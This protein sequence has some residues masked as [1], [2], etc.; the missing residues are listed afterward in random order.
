MKKGSAQVLFGM[1][2]LKSSDRRIHGCRAIVEDAQRRGA[3]L[4][5]EVDKQ[6]GKGRRSGS[7]TLHSFVKPTPKATPVPKARPRPLPEEEDGPWPQPMLHPRHAKRTKTDEQR[8]VV[9][10]E[11][12]E[13]DSD[14]IACLLHGRCAE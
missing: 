5:A 13:A 1:R 4:K 12:P 8:E 9:V 10:V 6:Q 14:S 7:R 11:Q 2:G 3:A